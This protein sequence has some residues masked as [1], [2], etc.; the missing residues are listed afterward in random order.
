MN[1]P[2]DSNNRTRTKRSNVESI[3]AVVLMMCILVFIGFYVKRHRKS[4]KEGSAKEQA[5]D[6]TQSVGI[7]RFALPADFRPFNEAETGELKTQMYQRG[8]AL[9]QSTGLGDPDQLK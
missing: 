6:R 7:F 8:S 1:E 2:T 4:A 5:N 3:V 9:A